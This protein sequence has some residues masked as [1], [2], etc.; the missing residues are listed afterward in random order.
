MQKNLTRGLSKGST[1]PDSRTWP[2]TPELALLWTISHLFPTSDM[3]HI[4]VSPARLLIGAYLG[5][6][7]IRSLRDIA[8]GLFL[9]TIVLEYENISKRLV[10]EAIVFLLNAVLRLHPHPYENKDDVPG[11]FPCL[12]FSNDR[13]DG[14]CLKDVGEG[15]IRAPDLV[16]M[17][18]LK[19]TYSEQ[20]KINLLSLAVD[21]LVRFADYYKSLDG[22]V[23]LY[24]PA[25]DILETMEGNDLYS[26]QISVRRSVRSINKL[27]LIIPAI[28]D[29]NYFCNGIYQKI[30][31]VFTPI[32]KTTPPSST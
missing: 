15:G 25:L 21:L 10:P 3:S 9:C 11:Y 1:L 7:R 27:S 22:F 12:N 28:L 14:L 32:K 6:C 17:L 2:G 24:Q 29:E 4:V 8:S 18:G 5:L 16:E 19:T 30:T 20:H 26:G 23:D 13:T 31:E